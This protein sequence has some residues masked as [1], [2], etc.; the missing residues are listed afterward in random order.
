MTHQYKKLPVTMKMWMQFNV[1]ALDVQSV[2]MQFNVMALD[3]QSQ[4]QSS[5]FH[6]ILLQWI[7]FVLAYPHTSSHWEMMLKPFRRTSCSCMELHYV[8]VSRSTEASVRSLDILT[9]QC[10][11]SPPTM[12]RHLISIRRP[13]GS[14][15]LSRSI[16]TRCLKKGEI[17]CYCC[18]RDYNSCQPNTVHGV[19]F[20]WH[21]T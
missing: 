1:M 3:V 6:L 17:S 7:E 19:V 13:A 18:Q 20:C 11:Y 5:S 4:L 14:S 16:T 15:T 12:S 8:S 2:W 10:Y 21:S 9:P